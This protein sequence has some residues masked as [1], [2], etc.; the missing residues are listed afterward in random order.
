M[1]VHFT[2]LWESLAREATEYYYSVQTLSVKHVQRITVATF[3]FAMSVL[4]GFCE[5]LH[6]GE[7]C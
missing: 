3:T 6:L 7:G 4:T 1:P 5:I 2:T